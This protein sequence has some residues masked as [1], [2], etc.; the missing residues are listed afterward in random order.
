MRFLFP[1]S[2]GTFRMCGPI[3]HYITGGADIMV[4]GMDLCYGSGLPRHR[5]QGLP[6]QW[7]LCGGQLEDEYWHQRMC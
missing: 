2:D 1:S 5:K 3:M 7:L 6:E 4:R